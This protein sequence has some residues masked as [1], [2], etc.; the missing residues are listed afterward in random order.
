M[1]KSIAVISSLAIALSVAGCAKK[2]DVNLPDPTFTVD[3]ATP[4]WKVDKEKA[5][6]SWYI[7]FDW[8]AQTWGNDVASK[9]ITEDTGVSIT[10]QNG[11]DDKLNTMLASGDLPDIITID[12]S[13]PLIKEA[14]K[15]AIPLDELAKKY[16]PYFLEGAAKPETLKY[17]TRDDGHIYGYP[18]FSNTK[19]DYE[20]GGIYGNQAFM[21][22]KD[23]YEKIGKPDMTT[24][25]GFL[26]A[27]EAVR[28][29]NAKD[30]LGKPVIPLGISIF[31]GGSEPNGVFNRTLADFIGVPVLTDDGKYYD[32]YTDPDFQ[33][34]LKTFVKA[35]QDGLTDKDMITMTK[36][37]KDA[38]LT[39]GSYFAYFAS[40]VNGE[41][42]ALSL[43]ANE[44]PD[45]VYIA[46][47]GPSST[48]GRKTAL[49]GTSIEGW[50]QTFISKTCK[51]PRK[52][53]E[54]VTYLVSEYGNNVMDFGREGE[55]Y[56]IVDGKP[57]LNKDLLEFKQTDPAGFE[58]KIGLT[59][60]LWLQDSAL[61]SRQMGLSQFPKALQQAKQWTVQYVVPQFELAGLNVYLSKESARNLEKINQN[62]SQTVAKILNAKSDAEVDQAMD[63]FVKYRQNNG[64]DKLVEEWNKQI[65]ANKKKLQ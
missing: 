22:R 31:N 5:N 29:L 34:W 36:D 4:S 14:D 45:K 54:L 21:V 60:H 26:S 59:T 62:W 55:T 53:M 42:D 13:S 57:V 49:P 38:R 9:Y 44:H 17:F 56:T 52:A 10:Y 43:W 24:P 23:I 35:R 63:A 6:L 46:V 7:N 47:N 11:T 39:N 37:D 50:T 32:R 15:F 28:K 64:Y 16:D 2:G 8:F 30:E 19:A 27:L 18:N 48:V 3:K 61:L 33:K 25:E 51:N 65:E 12:G 58:K 41:T 1:R 40:D 20:K